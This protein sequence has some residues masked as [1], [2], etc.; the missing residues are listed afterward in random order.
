MLMKKEWT[1]EVCPVCRVAASLMLQV[2]FGSSY[3]RVGG[4]L[5]W[6]FAELSSDYP[7]RGER[8]S[9]TPCFAWF[10]PCTRVVLSAG[11]P[12]ADFQP[13]ESPCP[14]ASSS[15]WIK[16]DAFGNLWVPQATLQKAVSSE[17][18]THSLWFKRQ[19]Q[20]N[21]RGCL[22]F[23]SS[24]K[25]ESQREWSFS[26]KGQS[27]WFPNSEPAYRGLTKPRWS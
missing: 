16:A 21:E 15:S 20:G 27:L 19:I 4:S 5:S 25:G 9:H 1:F 18:R 10:L 17:V 11:L 26:L 2:L 22:C 6:V 24:D 23:L 12:Q 8:C 3:L 13:D 7:T 14:S